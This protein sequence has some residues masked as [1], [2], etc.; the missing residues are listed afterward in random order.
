MTVNWGFSGPDPELYD[1][2][3]ELDRD[4]KISLLAAAEALLGLK[5]RVPPAI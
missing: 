2:I 3:A 5:R 4:D 1:R